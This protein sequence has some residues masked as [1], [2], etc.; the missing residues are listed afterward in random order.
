MIRPKSLQYV[1]FVHEADAIEAGPDGY[2]IVKVAF[3]LLAAHDPALAR[4][5]L[6]EAKG[7]WTKHPERAA[8]CAAMEAYARRTIGEREVTP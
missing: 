3:G 8:A 5:A 1:D 4:K 6:R 7:I 2:T